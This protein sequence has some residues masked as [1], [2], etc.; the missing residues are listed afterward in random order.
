MAKSNLV[1]VESPAKASTIKK[2]LGKNYEITASYGHIR[3]LPKSTIGV[4]I[5]NDFEPKYSTIKGKGDVTKKLRELA[6]KADKIYLAS[7]MDREGEAIAWHLAHVLKLDLNEKNRI[8]F[9]A[10]TTDAIKDAIKHPRKLDI[11]KVD[12]QQA[13]RILDRLVGYKISPLLWK[14]VDVNTSAGRVQSAAL[15]LICDLEDEIK[16]FIVEKYWE[17]NGEF[18]QGLSFLLNRINDEKT[19]RIFDE[20]IVKKLKK[21]IEDKTFEVVSTVVNKKTNSPPKPLKTSTLQ[22]LA[23]SYLGFSA[24]KTMRVAQGL[25]EGVEVDGELKGLITYMRTDSLRLSPEAKEMA[26]NFIIE[27]YGEKYWGKDTEKKEKN[28][29]KIQDAM[30]QLDLQMLL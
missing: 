30:R 29:K 25:Y 7:D 24:S 12:A 27:K 23:S 3:D 5:E 8:E 18:E 20:K 26:K 19:G 22:Q 11:D 1:I 10:I 14:S 28:A 17:V 13:R 2:I 6:K 9:N 4:D 21:D 15:K 16:A